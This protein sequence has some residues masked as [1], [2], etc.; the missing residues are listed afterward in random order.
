MLIV[1]FV[2][3]VVRFAATTF[4]YRSEDHQPRR[5][6]PPGLRCRYSARRMHPETATYLMKKRQGDPDGYQAAGQHRQRGKGDARRES[7][8]RDE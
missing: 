4:G 7:V 5:E 3:R 8:T 2:L 6:N 1:L